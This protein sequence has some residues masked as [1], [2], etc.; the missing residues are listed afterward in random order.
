MPAPRNFQKASPPSRPA[1]RPSPALGPGESV[2]TRFSRHRPLRFFIPSSSALKVPY[3]WPSWPEARQASVFLLKNLRIC[4]HLPRPLFRPLLPVLA[5]SL[6]TRYLSAPR[7]FP[8]PPPM[9]TFSSNASK[10]VQQTY[11]KITNLVIS[12]PLHPISPEYSPTLLPA[13]SPSSQ[14]ADDLKVTP[15]PDR[16]SFS[17]TWTKVEIFPRPAFRLTSHPQARPLLPRYAWSSPRLISPPPA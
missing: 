1:R 13:L 16:E 4:C 8:R 6:K 2:G 15:R 7:S 12:T 3:P 5:N 14:V 17:K 10:T 11:I 9:T